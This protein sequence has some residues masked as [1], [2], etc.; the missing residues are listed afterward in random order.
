MDWISFRLTTALYNDAQFT[1]NSSTTST[2]EKAA[3]KESLTAF[4][5]AW[6]LETSAAPQGYSQPHAPN[7]QETIARVVEAWPS[8][9]G[10]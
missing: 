2:G 10:Q 8:V 3:L 6:Q 5:L 9:F 1:L 7:L 4:E